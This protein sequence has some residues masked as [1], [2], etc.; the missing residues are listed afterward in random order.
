MRLRR[1]RRLKSVL[2]GDYEGERFFWSDDNDDDAD[3]FK[4]T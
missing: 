2:M 4:T 1:G 3:G